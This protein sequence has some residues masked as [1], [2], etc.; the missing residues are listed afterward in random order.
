[1]CGKGSGKRPMNTLRATEYTAQ[2]RERA[3]SSVVDAL[4]ERPLSHFDL[5]FIGGFCVPGDTAI[6]WALEDERIYEIQA[7]VYAIN[8]SS[9]KSAKAEQNWARIDLS[10]PARPDFGP[11]VETI[12]A[13]TNMEEDIPADQILMQPIAFQFDGLKLKNAA[14]AAKDGYWFYTTDSEKAACD[15]LFQLY[16]YGFHGA[17]IKANG[18]PKDGKQSF[19]LIAPYEACLDYFDVEYL[20][21]QGGNYYLSTLEYCLSVAAYFSNSGVDCEVELYNHPIHSGLIKIKL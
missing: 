1:M 4:R 14:R 8:Y 13:G 3:V 9:F 10:A 11:L 5:V 21:H 18:K 16:R 15:A 6:K 12:F 20:E 19:K 7:S 17:S 2:Q